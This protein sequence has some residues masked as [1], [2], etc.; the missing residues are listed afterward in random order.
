MKKI[1]LIREKPSKFGGAEVYLSRLSKALKA[2]GIEYQIVNS[3]FP[4]FLPS[5]LRI[6][7]FNFQVC[8]TKKNKL[9]FS[10]E[11]I[12]CPDVYR[13][14]DGVHKVFLNIEN[15][16]KLNPLHPIY[17][18][19]EKRCFN[20]AKFIIANSNMIK[21]EI[22]DTYG[23]RPNKI[24]VVY[25]GVESKTIN[26]ESSF[27]KLSKEFDIDKNSS[28]LLYVGSGFKRKG[29]EEFLE[30]IAKLKNQSVKAFIIGKE[31]NLEYYQQL[32]KDLKI[33]KTV[34]FTGPRA[35]VD[36]F[37][38]ISD[39]FLFPT[40]YEPFSNVVLE[41]MSFENAVFTTR[42][43]GAHEILTDEYIMASSKDFSVAKKID[44]LLEDAKELSDIKRENK[45]IAS[46]LSIELNMQ[47]TIEVINK[48]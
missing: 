10:L 16:S 24:D 48:V 27:K 12:V 6:I 5:W 35:D 33:D 9:Y 28:I 47:K 30:I 18:F 23:I 44:D 46:K 19:L 41:A 40:R 8:L 32:S 45:L 14:G 43:N 15:K 17:L 34:I 21:D 13:A 37:Y 3:I 7:L 4:S 20:N 1:H 11:R 29:V 36:D 25:N 39:I 22:I 38:T 26:H 31:K 2:E 42:Q